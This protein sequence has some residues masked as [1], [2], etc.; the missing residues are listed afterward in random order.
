[1]L[2]VYSNAAPSQVQVPCPT[3][4]TSVL[5]SPRLS[6]STILS[7]SFEV[8]SACWAVQTEREF[9]SGPKPGQHVRPEAR[10]YVTANKEV[11]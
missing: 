1:M 6:A 7:N 3:P 9:P 8:S 2:K 10:T 5:R 11:R 4:T